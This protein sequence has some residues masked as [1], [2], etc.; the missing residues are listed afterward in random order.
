MLRK[1]MMVGC[2]VFVASQAQ[3]ALVAHFPFDVDLNSTVGGITGAA[4]GTPLVV[5]TP[6]AEVVVGAGA[7]KL[8]G[9]T[10][11]EDMDGVIV[12]NPLD[13][14]LGSWTFTAWARRDGDN[15][16]PNANAG[17]SPV[18][19]HIM[20]KNSAI[21]FYLQGTQLRTFMATA[22]PGGGHLTISGSSVTD[23]TWAHV[24]LTIDRTT[25]KVTNYL[26]G[27]VSGPIRDIDPAKSIVSPN[28]S[29]G[30]VN[31]NGG[32]RSL[33]GGLDDAAVFDAALTQAEIQGIMANGVPEPT[34]ML[35][36]SLGGLLM[37]KRGQQQRG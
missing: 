31:A 26:N 35:L 23:G 22:S 32:I 9:S 37:R 14:G 25:N 21:N 7:L 4:Y 33:N 24:A 12:S 8:D 36:L 29:L 17:A 15:V 19:Q 6:P 20:N 27:V 2:I 34:T 3:G 18:R 16:A 1:M 13:P 10:T 30:F 11:L 28:F 5:T